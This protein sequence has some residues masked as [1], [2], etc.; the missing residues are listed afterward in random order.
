VPEAEIKEK[1]E[2][3]FRPELPDSPSQVEPVDYQYD[4]DDADA[5]KEAR[6]DRA[7][8]EL[9]EWELSHPEFI[10]QNGQTF[11]RND[12]E[13][14]DLGSGQEYRVI[15]HD[16]VEYYA[17]VDAPGPSKPQAPRG[18]ARKSWENSPEKSLEKSKKAASPKGKAPQKPENPTSAEKKS[19]GASPGSPVE[20]ENPLRVK[21]TP[22]TKALSDEQR[23]TLRKFFKL[24]EGIV[25]KDVWVSLTNKERQKE[26]AKRA[27]PRWATEAVLRKASNLQDILEGKITKANAN[28]APRSPK[29]ALAKPT[30]QAMEA[31]Q[32]L[33][34]DFRGVG[35]FQK[36]V[37][38]RE[39]AFRKRFD[40]LVADYGQ[41]PCF[42]KLR[43]HPENQGRSSRSPGKRPSEGGGSELLDMV[44]LIGTLTR[45]F[46]GK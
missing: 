15:M 39:K 6:M 46:S 43:S 21:G 5:G 38:S 45:A 23:A 1:V 41:Q 33:K 44:R 14:I 37:T 29:V 31:W 8:R 28:A 32:Q 35:L 10:E 24:E 2:E 12:I 40:Q 16:G 9:E 7:A 11:Y 36:P 26:M 19:T 17:V 4:S 27:I 20:E 30:A 25:P 22:K 3:I 18:E 13:Y 42:P 34:A